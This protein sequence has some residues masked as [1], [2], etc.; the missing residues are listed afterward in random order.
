MIMFEI[1][2]VL[3]FVMVIGTFIVTGIKGV[4]EWNNNNNSP[5]LSVNAMVGSK[6]SDVSHHHHHHAN[7]HNHVTHSTTYYVTFQV[8]STDR[9]ELRVSGSEYGMLIEGDYGVLS[10][11]GTRYLG[12]ERG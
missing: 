4:T 8:D 7:G 11:Q 3:V 10:F 9:M 6:R 2:F 1:M 12:F 5:R